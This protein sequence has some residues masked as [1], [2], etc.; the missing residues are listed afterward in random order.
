MSRVSKIKYN[1]NLSVAEN[2]DKN[3]TTEATIRT[4]LQAHCIDRRR[5]AKINYINAI[6]K[7]LKENPDASK[8]A[9]SRN[10]VVNGKTISIQTVRKYWDYAKGT[11]RL[12]ERNQHKV[13]EQYKSYSA[14]LS[15]IPVDVIKKYLLDREDKRIS[16]PKTEPQPESQPQPQ[17]KT[18]KKKVV[19]VDELKSLIDELKEVEK[20]NS[21]S[22]QYLPQ[23]TIAELTRW[24]E[25]DAS[26]YL[27]YAFRKKPDKRK[28]VWIPFGNMNKGFPF[29]LYGNQCMTSESAY[30]CGMFSE[31]TPEHISIQ[32]QLLKESNGR[33]AK[34][35]IRHYSEA[36]ARKDW[37]DFNIQWM[38]YVVWCKVQGNAEF[39][40]LL[41]G[42]PDGATIVEDTT[43]QNGSKGNDTTIFWGAKNNERKDFDAIL[44]KYINATEKEKK[45]GTKKKMKLEEFNNFTD[46]GTFRGRNVMGKILTICR[47]CLQDG[48]EPPIDYELLKSKHIYLLGKELTF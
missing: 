22:L 18:R 38:L 42:V 30:I 19:D 48:T 33:K 4:Y 37:Y 25:Y 24:E 27:C 16:K 29:D 44:K 8:N 46:Y 45:K 15:K 26:K 7:Y 43:F 3:H 32:E 1:P 2:A 31:N 41:M 17:R 23:P 14:I 9:V 28:G 12:T 10:V 21:E 35:D 34:K 47:N 39:R 6:K 13:E 20:K 5:E 40:N 11:K 36:L